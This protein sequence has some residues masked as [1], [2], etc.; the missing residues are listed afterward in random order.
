MSWCLTLTILIASGWRQNKLDYFSR[1]SD[2]GRVT[3]NL[4]LE[5]LSSRALESRCLSKILELWLFICLFVCHPS[6]AFISISYSFSA[7]VWIMLGLT[8]A[9]SVSQAS[10]SAFIL[11]GSAN[12]CQAVTGRRMEGECDG[13]TRLWSPSVQAPLW[14]PQVTSSALAISL[15]WH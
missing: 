4:E 8:S 11:L 10:Q 7:P 3:K 2:W 14:L 12:Q 6:L 13:E 9:D 15:P 1:K 5:Y